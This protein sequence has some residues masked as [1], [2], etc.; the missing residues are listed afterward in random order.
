M[1]EFVQA[2]VEIS[3]QILVDELSDAI[4]R[5]ENLLTGED[6]DFG[7][8]CTI[9]GHKVVPRTLDDHGVCYVV[10]GQHVKVRICKIDYNGV[11]G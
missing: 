11:S 1:G 7:T 4:F 2:R 5:D 9:A 3:A 8:G 10:G 6:V